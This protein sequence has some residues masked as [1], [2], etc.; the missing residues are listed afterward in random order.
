MNPIL[1]W[2]TV[3]VCGLAGVVQFFFAVT[4][5]TNASSLALWPTPISIESV[6]GGEVPDGY[7]QI[8]GGLLIPSIAYDEHTGRTY[9]SRGARL[10]SEASLHEWNKRELPGARS[11]IQQPGILVGMNEKQM[12]RLWPILNDGQVLHRPSALDPLAHAPIGELLTLPRPSEDLRP[13]LAGLTFQYLDFEEHPLRV[14]SF[15]ALFAILELFI[16]YEL[17]FKVRPV[18]SPDSQKAEF[19]SEA[20]REKIPA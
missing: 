4:T 20:V 18:P 17:A 19:P 9:V 2:G 1:R 8:T 5:F 3:T 11:D 16:A 13:E 14:Y 7:V 12:A 6:E 10:L 15:H